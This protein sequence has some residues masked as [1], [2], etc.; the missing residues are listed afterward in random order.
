MCFLGLCF[1]SCAEKKKDHLVIGV[2]MLSMQNEFIQQVAD[3]ME[4]AAKKENVELIIVDAERSSLK[5]IEQVESFVN[6]QVDAIIL[7]PCE[8]EASSPAI[9]KAKA[10]GIPIVN[11]NSSTKAEPDAMVGS[12]DATSAKMAMELINKKL[13]G[14]GNVL[15]IQGY[16]GQAAQIDRERGA[17]EVLAANKGLTLIASQTG[18]WDRAK[19]MNLME[20]WIQSYGTKINAVFAQNDEMGLGA[21]QALLDAGKKNQVYVVSIDGIK[22]AKKS[23]VEGKLDVTIVQNATKQGEGAVL[24]AL[25]LAKKEAGVARKIVVPFEIFNK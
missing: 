20:N 10:A 22:D 4:V 15:M 19:S 7:N 12:D 5:Q 18:E 1:L 17:K 24:T 8:Y 16:M 6:Q 25:K 11:V 3:A 21:V 14:R 2:S 9:E 23:V 13:N